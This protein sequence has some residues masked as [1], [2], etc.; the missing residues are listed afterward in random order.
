MAAVA[1]LVGCEEPAGA[2]FLEGDE[3]PIA[4]EWAGPVLDGG[5]GSRLAGTADRVWA[6]SPFAD[7]VD[8]LGPAGSLQSPLTG[9]SGSFFGSGLAIVDGALAI[10][11][12]GRGEV[13][14][15]GKVVA[16]L[17]GM[18][19]VLA[20]EGARWVASTPSGWRASDSTPGTLGV[21]P[22]ALAWLGDEVLAGSALGETALWAG[23]PP[24]G[25]PREQAY[26]ERGYALVVCPDANGHPLAWAGAP[27]AGTIVPAGGAPV[28]PGT[29]RFGAAMACGSEAGVL[30][31]GAPGADAHAGALYRVAGA[32][33][34]QVLAGAPGDE[35][36][37][38]VL[39]AGGRVFVGAPGG[40]G[41][42]GRVLAR[43]EATLAP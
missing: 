43:P 20:A 13:L 32:E 23:S 4:D 1:L 5:F 36:G 10:G 33:A 35:L 41:T 17:P 22:S 19:G 34:V 37:T 12:P 39:L 7:R 25:T 38:A 40:A 2:E 29:G 11:A 3:P 14:V 31:V 42:A 6:A 15:G 18:G 26:D 21:R 8:E 27:G 24:V 9:E 30:W 28:G 16:T